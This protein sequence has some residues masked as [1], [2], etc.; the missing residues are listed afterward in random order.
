[1]ED[2]GKFV[3]KIANKRSVLIK[4]VVASF[5]T[6]FRAKDLLLKNGQVRRE[7]SCFL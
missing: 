6:V 2:D 7:T 4:K 5:I 3:E 1:M